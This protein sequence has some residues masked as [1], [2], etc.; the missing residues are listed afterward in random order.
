VF[1]CGSC[2]VNFFRCTV[3]MYTIPFRGF[4]I[5]FSEKK[6]EKK[7]VTLTSFDVV[8]TNFLLCVAFSSF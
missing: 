5:M 8:Q 7:T 3:T 1:V 2:T 6:D 4:I